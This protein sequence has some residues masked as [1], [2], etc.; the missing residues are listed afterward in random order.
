MSRTF[1][2]LSGV[3]AVCGATTAAK[4]WESPLKRNS[5]RRVPMGRLTNIEKGEREKTNRER[6]SWSNRSLHTRT[7]QAMIDSTSSR[8]EPQKPQALC[9]MHSG[10]K[11]PVPNLWDRKRVKPGTWER[12]RSPKP[13]Q[14]VTNAQEGRPAEIVNLQPVGP[15]KALVSANFHHTAVST[16]VVWLEMEV[17]NNRGPCPALDPRCLQNCKDLQVPDST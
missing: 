17:G 2:S 3:A 1:P 12:Q 11:A 9:L 13:C 7:S 10:N 6:E 4:V 15:A 8:L 16:G 5:G 14:S